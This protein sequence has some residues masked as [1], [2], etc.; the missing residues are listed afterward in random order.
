M[1]YVCL[2]L[3]YDG[4]DFYGWQHQPQRRTVQ[5]ELEKAVHEV[6]GVWTRM[7]G[8]SRTDRGVHAFGQAVSF[9]TETW[10]SNDALCKALNAVLPFDMVV[11]G[12]FDAPHG[13][14]ATR[15][16]VR[17]RYR[18]V[19]QD[20]RPRDP[21]GRAYSWHVPRELN[22]DLMQEAAKL[23]EGTHDFR[24]FQSTGSS[25]ESTVR[26]VYEVLVERRLLDHGWR[27]II[28]VEANGFLY[29][30]VR[31][32]AGTL[33]YVGQGKHPPSWVAE[34]LASQKRK[35]AGMAAPA[36]GLFLLWIEF[37]GEREDA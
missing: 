6:T 4:T 8:S 33:L 3:A 26:T 15:D 11:L 1:R 29:N 16:S 12:V 32:I 5:G 14:H 7:H 24:A 20:G 23:I 18:Y 25:R 17:K 27:T 37:P 35:L 22:V 31:N 36:E 9:A 34:V 28:E 21:F 10:L 30:M 13:F 19:I 2:K